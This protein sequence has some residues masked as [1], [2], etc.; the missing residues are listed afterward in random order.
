[1]LDYFNTRSDFNGLAK[2]STRLLKIASLSPELRKRLETVKSKALLKQ[3][4]EQVKSK[5]D[6]DPFASG[7]VY[8]EAAMNFSD[9]NLRSAALEQALAR[10]K[11]EKDINT[12]I[13]T[14]HTIAEAEHDPQ[15]KAAILIGA[16]EQTLAVG[17]YYQTIKLW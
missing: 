13:R 8:L 12:F 11:A 10:S 17:R 5:A 7:K 4:D 2:W 3:I 1:L 14:A 16:G 6:Y 9:E 15:K